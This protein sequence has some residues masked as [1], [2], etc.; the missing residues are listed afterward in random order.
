[1]ADRQP[2]PTNPHASA[3][4]PAIDAPAADAARPTMTQTH[5][6]RDVRA[7]DD[8]VQLFVSNTPDHTFALE[9]VEAGERSWQCVGAWSDETIQA[10]ARAIGPGRQEGAA[11]RG[12]R[13]ERSGSG[14]GGG[15]GSGGSAGFA[16]AGAGRPLGA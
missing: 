2:S 5:Q 3:S 11:A 6:L 10:V 4:S 16:R 9:N 12:G 13:A 7:A 1:M 8:A 14:A 15:N